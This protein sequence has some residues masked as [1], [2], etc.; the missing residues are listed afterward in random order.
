MKR[1]SIFPG[2][3]GGFVRLGG[4]A[5]QGR[6]V[7]KPRSPKRAREHSLDTG[8]EKKPNE[9]TVGPPHYSGIAVQAVKTDN[10]FN[11]IN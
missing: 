9:I 4:N 8:A 10:L 1:L 11:K 7:L 3:S 6:V 2:R 5:E